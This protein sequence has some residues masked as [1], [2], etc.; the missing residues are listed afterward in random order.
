MAVT[1]G[2]V[3]LEKLRA[4][5]GEHAVTGPERYGLSWAGKSDA[6][7]A[8][9]Q[10]TTAT[11]MPAPSESVQWDAASN[12][13]IEGDNLEVL[14]ALQQSY[15]GKV[16]LIFIDPP[17][18]TRNDFIYPDNFAEGLQSYLQFTQQVNQEGHKL[19][20]NVELNGRYH[21]RWLSMIYP[22]LF[23]AR[24]L[25][26]DD[27]VI[28]VSIDDHEVHNLRLAADEVFGEENFLGCV[29]WQK[30]YAPANDKADL[31]ASHDYI[32]V[33]TRGRNRDA[34]GKISAVLSREE[35]TSEMDAAYENPD[36]DN[37]GPWKAGDYTCNKSA[38]ERPSL[39]YAIRNPITEEDVFPKRTRVWA[40][41]RDAHEE[42]VRENR[43]WWGLDGRNRTPSYK[44]FLSE[45]SG[46]VAQTVWTWQEV[47]HN[48]EAKKEL[49]ALF[50][51]A[52]EVFGTPKPLR[53]I[54]KILRLAT[55]PEG[56][57]IVLDFFA[58]SGTTGQ[59]VLELNKEDGGNRTFILVQLP[60]ATGRKDYPTIS[61]IT[62]ERVRR[63]IGR[64]EK[65]QADELTLVAGL[66]PG[67]KVFKLAPSNFA[68][69]DPALAG[70]DPAKLAE[71][72]QMTAD[73]LREDAQEQALL[74]E[75]I[76]KCGLP[77]DSRAERIDAAGVPV[78]RLDG[79]RLLICLA[80]ELTR[81]ALRSMVALAPKSVLCLDIGFK[82]NDALKVNAELEFK[83]HDI[84]FRTA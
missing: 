46:I 22:R 56:S 82:G 51:E 15:Y 39:F 19:S 57:D 6:L 54:Q 29:I 70:A 41:S 26:R 61:E 9:R 68:V 32:L 37:R 69:W 7:K 74:Y 38:E 63:A 80:R 73:N 52:T 16:K 65:G 31:S 17:Y 11:L 48:D 45:V 44:R 62:K 23:L 79:G 34:Q 18:N 14:K 21:S 42:N 59:A 60:E 8:L 4:L 64:M 67:F 75:L 78:Y 66:A 83:S 2:R 49:L 50:P 72:W 28:F 77:L 55:N 3:D 13:I 43:V 30:K 27:G 1:D 25:L 24:N 76:L 84:Q 71:Q 40:Y 58:G 12:A 47:G 10:L 53:L 5:M 33:Y 20:T 36:H 35:R 81:E